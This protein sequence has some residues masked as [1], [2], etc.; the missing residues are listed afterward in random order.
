[1]SNQ[2]RIIAGKFR[3][4]KIHF[5]DQ[6]G[7]RPTGDR[8][9][10]TL[11][12]W[13]QQDIVGANCLD[14]FAGSGVFGFEALSRGAAQVT[15]IDQSPKIIKSIAEN[16]VTLGC[17]IN[18]IVAR[19]PSLPLAEQLKSQT[20]DIVFIDP[21]FSADLLEQSLD[22]VVE[23]L[24]LSRGAVI[25]CEMP[26]KADISL[27]LGWQAY[28]DKVAGQVRYMLLTLAT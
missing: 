28:R 18:A 15:A 3:G 24:N 22:W 21:P 1:M 10:E 9:R 16:A 26:K 17:E 23:Q 6:E 2:V 4:R 20:F 14:L 19:V 12:N 7:L 8:I 13:L 5:L 27:P 11:F 25:Y